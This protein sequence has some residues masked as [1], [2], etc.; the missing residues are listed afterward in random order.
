VGR[1]VSPATRIVS[2]SSTSTWPGSMGVAHMA[3]RCKGG[4]D[5]IECAHFAEIP[6]TFFGSFGADPSRTTQTLRAFR[7][8]SVLGE[9]NI[10][11]MEVRV[12]GCGHGSG[13]RGRLFRRADGRGWT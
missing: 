11:A 4:R 7:R 5:R 10:L 2:P 13:C 12:A 9:T 6:K 1:K 3:L 8:A